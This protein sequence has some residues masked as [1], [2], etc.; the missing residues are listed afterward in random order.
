MSPSPICPDTKTQHLAGDKSQ[1]MTLVQ[2][3]T[4]LTGATNATLLDPRWR[5]LLLRPSLFDTALSAAPGGLTLPLQ[6]HPFR[7]IRLLQCRFLTTRVATARK[8][9][10]NRLRYV[11]FYFRI[12]WL[13]LTSTNKFLLFF[14][15]LTRTLCNR[16]EHRKYFVC[17]TMIL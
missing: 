12:Y 16:R 5:T 14:I 17:F 8:F 15:H 13:K 1:K 7:N 3:K 10:T 2:L 6:K 4:V 11:I 9:N